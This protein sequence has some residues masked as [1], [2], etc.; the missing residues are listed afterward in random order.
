M[1]KNQ[2]C[3]ATGSFNNEQ[4]YIFMFYRNH[5]SIPRDIYKNARIK[6]NSGNNKQILKTE[7]LQKKS[8]ILHLG[9]ITTLTSAVWGSPS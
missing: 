2:Y 8:K 9:R 6:T 7:V 4:R 3:N 1:E 5:A